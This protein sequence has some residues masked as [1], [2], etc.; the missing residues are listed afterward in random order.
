MSMLRTG[1]PYLVLVAYFVA[2]VVMQPA[3][4]F[5][6]PLYQGTDYPLQ[7]KWTRFVYDD[8]DVAA[9]VLRAENSKRGRL[10]GEPLAVGAAMGTTS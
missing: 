6:P 2:I 9:W 8:G 10:A 1:W 3:A 4:R 5:V 7:G